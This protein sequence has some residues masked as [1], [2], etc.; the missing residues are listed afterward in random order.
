MRVRLVDGAWSRPALT[1]D[2][3]RG[4]LFV[5]T[6]EFW[7]PNALV[8]IHLTDPDDPRPIALLG[9]VTRCDPRSEL[10]PPGIGVSLFGNGE[11]VRK[12]WQA[13]VRR[14]G[15]AA[16]G[17]TGSL[18]DDGAID[19]VRRA[20]TRRQCDLPARITTTGGAQDARVLSASEGGVFVCVPQLAAVGSRAHLAVQAPGADPIEVGGTVVRAADSLDPLE[21]GVAL[22]IDAHPDSISTWA[23]FMLVH[24]PLQRS[25]PTFLPGLRRTWSDADE[26]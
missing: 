15:A 18:D 11:S 8:R 3:S 21:K 5:R 16:A 13:L 23:D 12:R 20:H 25:L 9:I 19:A 4:G 1:H 6:D 22:R 7:V 10:R 14:A 17:W 26:A 2:V 24:V